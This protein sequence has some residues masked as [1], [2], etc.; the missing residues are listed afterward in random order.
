MKFTLCSQD[1]DKTALNFKGAEEV[2]KFILDAL[3]EKFQSDLK[4]DK[5]LRIFPQSV[6]INAEKGSFLTADIQL[7]FDILVS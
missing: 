7:A 5:K 6:K 3:N 2:E 4:I 1:Y